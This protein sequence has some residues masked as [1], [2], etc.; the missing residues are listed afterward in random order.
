VL[1]GAGESVSGGVGDG[2]VGV[3]A[4][5]GVLVRFGEVVLPAQGVQVRGTGGPVVVPFDE[6]IDFVSGVVATAFRFRA[7]GIRGE[8]VVPEFLGGFVSGAPEIEEV[9]G[10]GFEGPAPPRVCLGGELACV[11]GVDGSVA[12]DFPGVVGQV[13]QGGQVD[14]DTDVDA[15]VSVH[16]GQ[17]TGGGE[18]VG[19]G[20]DGGDQSVGAGGVPATGADSRVITGGGAGVGVDVTRAGW[21]PSR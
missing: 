10:D 13:E 14:E 12:E 16:A 15:G 1:A 5:P 6:V 4:H 2:A 21:W 17:G 8:D 19:G 20:V 7:F 3:H 11:V 18:G 9:A